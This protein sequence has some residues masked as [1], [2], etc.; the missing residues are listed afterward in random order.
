M[1]KITNVIQRNCKNNGLLSFI[2]FN[3]FSS[4]SPELKKTIKNSLSEQN[5][6][7]INKND[8][9][10]P[11]Q[12]S[13]THKSMIA[14]AFASLNS[15]ENSDIKTPQTDGKLLNAGNVEELLSVSE[16]SGVSRRHA[17]KVN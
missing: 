5:E 10:K 8:I 4:S 14:A 11:E 16:G 1:L 3:N 2:K 13:L 17:L 15:N 12:I 9:R 7:L 6:A